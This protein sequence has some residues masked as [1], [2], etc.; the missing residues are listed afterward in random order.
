MKSQHYPRLGSSEVD[1]E[2]RIQMQVIYESSTSRRI[3]WKKKWGS[4]PRGRSQMKSCGREL[5][6]YPAGDL[7]SGDST[8]E[9]RKL[10][11][12]PPSPFSHWSRTTGYRDGDSKLPQSAGEGKAA[13]VA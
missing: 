6:P 3:W 5:H 2:M 13:P 4:S 9:P 1:P 11:G 7:C 12:P 10:A 8:S